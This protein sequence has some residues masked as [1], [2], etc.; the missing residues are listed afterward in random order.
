MHLILD[1]DGT[2]ISE[3]EPIILRPHLQEFLEFCFDLFETVS[4]WSAAGQKHVEY[5]A[6][7]ILPPGRKWLFVRYSKHCHQ[8]Y[9]SQ[10]GGIYSE[11]VMEK[12]LRNIWKCQTYRKLGITK[13]NTLIIDNTPSV[14]LKNYGNAVYVPSF[15]TDSTDQVLLELME[16]LKI[17]IEVNNVR[18][19]EKRN[20]RNCGRDCLPSNK[21]FEKIYYLF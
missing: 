8:T 12:R 14:C 9:R 4:I 21:I 1:I 16:Y 10:L 19:V 13:F 2:L 6:N 17:L 7:L 15:Y 5:I 11:I 3:N 18:T 20:W